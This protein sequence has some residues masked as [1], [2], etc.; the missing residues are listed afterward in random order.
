MVSFCVI[1]SSGTLLTALGMPGVALTGP[2]LYYLVSS[3]FAV[4]T[5]FLLVE[6]ISRTEDTPQNVLNTTLEAFGIDDSDNQ[7]D[8][9]GEVVGVSI[10]AALAFLGSAFI[11]C[12]LIIAGLPPFSGF[13]AKFALLSQAVSLTSIQSGSAPIY[14][15]FLVGFMIFSGMVTVIVMSRTG[16]RVF[17][18]NKN[19]NSP[20]LSIREALPISILI[21]LCLY[22]TIFVND[23]MVYMNATAK[24]LDNPAEYVE[25]VFSK[26][27]AKQSSGFYNSEGNPL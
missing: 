5:A 25:A 2:S 24:S 11:V 12:T 14:A 13:I 9:S 8:Y 17:W 10:P 27:P 7:S 4:A 22:I 18:A 21:G 3:V 26:K 1:I 23:V 15:W 6:I 19:L 16:I 20:K